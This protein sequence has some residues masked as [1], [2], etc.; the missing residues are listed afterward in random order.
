MFET[1][2]MEKL[3]RFLKK[4]KK[5]LFQF[6]G[7]SSFQ[8]LRLVIQTFNGNP[9]NWNDKNIVWEYTTAYVLFAVINK[10]TINNKNI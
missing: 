5:V 10:L 3:N 2:T 7:C 9:T 8:S 6:C 1:L 4:T